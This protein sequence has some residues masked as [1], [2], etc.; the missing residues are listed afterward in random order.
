LRGSMLQYFQ[1]EKQV[2]LL[3]LS[4]GVAALLAALLLLRG[5]GAWRSMAWPLGAVALIQVSVGGAV[6]FRTDRQVAGLVQA[7]E[8]DPAAYRTAEVARMARVM[9]SFRDYEVI[10]VVLVAVGIA[11]TAFFPHR[12]ALYAVGVGLLAQAAFMLVLDLVAAQRG[13][14]YLEA[15]TRL[16]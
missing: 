14:V 5:G 12:Q 15:L 9:S 4:V 2:A 13:R 3:F 11:L 10:E 16:G 8:V 6:F 7:L 1:A